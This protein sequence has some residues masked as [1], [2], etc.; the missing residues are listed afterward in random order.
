M[1]EPP[2]T[3]DEMFDEG[4]GIS[5]GGRKGSARERATLLESARQARR[6]RAVA[7]APSK[8]AAAL[9]RCLRGWFARRRAAALLRASLVEAVQRSAAPDAVERRSL[10][11]RLCLLR[12]LR[13]LPREEDEQLIEASCER[14]LSVAPP[15]G[16]GPSGAGWCACAAP[17]ATAAFLRRA[18]LLLP[19][20]VGQPGEAAGRLLLSICGL[21]HGRSESA[22][23]PGIAEQCTQH[24]GRDAFGRGNRQELSSS[25]GS[26]RTKRGAKEQRLPN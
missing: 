14:L 8:S 26:Q 6:Q 11:R 10:T 17:G 22:R 19:V 20:L 24:A 16:D 5:L 12:R 15:L 2:S 4:K 13:T 3:T 25:L 1:L 23:P 7:A 18:S 21:A 9:G